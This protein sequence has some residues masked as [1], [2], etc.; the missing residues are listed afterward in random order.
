MNGTNDGVAK[1]LVGGS[2][3]AMEPLQ[4]VAQVAIADANEVAD[5]LLQPAMVTLHAL[6]VIDAAAVHL[7]RRSAPGHPFPGHGLDEGG[8]PK[9]RFI[10]LRLGTLDGRHHASCFITD[11]PGDTR[12]LLL[13]VE[14][15]LPKNERNLSKSLSWCA[16]PLARLPNTVTR[17]TGAPASCSRFLKS[18]ATLRASA[19]MANP[20]L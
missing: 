7:E 4:M 10:H 16:S 14:A 6:R 2:V 3:R 20:P 15:P 9:R 8:K 17:N 19:S 13:N 12:D 11:L 1:A 5:D 18:C